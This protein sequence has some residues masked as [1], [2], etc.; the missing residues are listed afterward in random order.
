MNSSVYFSFSWICWCKSLGYSNKASGITA[1]TLIFLMTPPIWVNNRIYWSWSRSRHLLGHMGVFYLKSG[2]RFMTTFLR[3][4][5]NLVW[6][7]WAI[8]APRWWC[9][10]HDFGLFFLFASPSFLFLVWFSFDFILRYAR[11]V[12]LG[13][14]SL[15]NALHSVVEW[16][17]RGHRGVGLSSHVHVILVFILNQNLLLRSTSN[18][19]SHF[20]ALLFDLRMR[21]YSQVL[22]CLYGQVVELGARPRSQLSDSTDSHQES[23]FSQLTPLGLSEMGQVISDWLRTENG[24][25]HINACCHLR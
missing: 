7:L 9:L 10:N 16:L 11:N 23:C 8:T 17:N 4:Y 3:R 24:L 1:F 19:F 25:F 13:L 2:R 12:L 14:V 18:L 5:S 22:D 21:V 20:M 6:L 15:R